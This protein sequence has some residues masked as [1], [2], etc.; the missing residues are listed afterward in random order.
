MP[1]P[2]YLSMEGNTQGNITEGS[3]GED[4]VGSIGQ[5][6]HVDEVL[7]EAFNHEINIPTDPQSGQP[8]GQRVH[9]PLV[10]TKVFDK[11]SPKLYNA[12]ASGERMKK[13]LIKW[14]RTAADGTQQHYFTHELEEAVIVN[15]KAYMPNCQDPG[16]AQFTHLEDV[17]FTYRKIT[18][19]HEKCGT[20]GADD[21]KKPTV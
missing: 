10:I 11:S 12:C 19:T 6:A 16:K 4:S 2:A 18:W 8:A 7:V 1:T 5:E 13:V 14:W 3:M 20:S 21:W 9:K 17:S 15:I